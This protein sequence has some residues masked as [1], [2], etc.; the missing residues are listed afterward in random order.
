MPCRSVGYLGGRLSREA[1]IRQH[2]PEYAVIG[3][4]NRHLSG[5]AKILALFMGN[6]RY[7]SDRPLL[8]DEVL[9][10]RSVIRARSPAMVSDRLKKRGVTHLIVRYDLFTY[11]AENSFPANKHE[12]LM[13]FFGEKTALL[14]S[15]GGYGLYRL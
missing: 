5:D 10:Y 14:I 15:E 12:L 4:A 3:Y 9:L 13:K 8:F 2:R 11:W 1:Y 7:Y 6:R